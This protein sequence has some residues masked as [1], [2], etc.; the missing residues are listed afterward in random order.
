[1][2]KILYFLFFTLHTAFY[3]QAPGIQWQKCF[4]GSLAEL[5]YSI[6]QTTDGG[7]IAAG[8][9]SSSNGQV[10]ENH[11]VA[12]YW[13]VK[14]TSTG[15]LQWQKSLGGSGAESAS[16]VFQTTDGGYI[17]TGTSNSVDGDVTGNHGDLD[18][19]VVKMDPGGNLQWQ[20]SFGGSNIERAESI[21]QTTD[22]GYILAGTT[23]STDGDVTAN[24]GGQDYWV[25]KLSPDGNIQ[26][27]KSLGGSGWENAVSIQ[28]TTDGGYIV[29]GSTTDSLDGD[30]TENN[31]LY[32][33]WVVKLD[34]GGAIEW[35]KSYGGM[36]DDLA[37]SVQQTLDGGYIIAGTSSD[38]V[39]GEIPT[40]PGIPDYWIIKTDSLGNMEWNKLLGGSYHDNTQA[41]RPTQDGGYIIGGWSVSTD[42][43]VTGNHGNHD[44]WVTKLDN[45]GNLQWQKSLGGSNVDM[46]HSIEQT[47]DGGYIM[48]GYTFSTNG[49][50]SGNHGSVDFWVVKLFSDQLNTLETP[51]VNKTVLYP[52]PAKDIIFL[53]HL[54]SETMVQIT[55][56]AGRNLLNKKY[57]EEKININTSPFTNGMYMIQVQHK[58][59]ILLSEKLKIAK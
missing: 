26:W 48:L 56:M 58:G 23:S 50:V 28:Q 32:D 39:T 19:W 15:T 42:G 2:N 47:A 22:G 18:Y 51:S 12:D 11:G 21:Q 57:T 10:T 25:L 45:L 4:G 9:S 38:S 41:V 16:S 36:G 31:G 43:Q 53:D 46:L 17:A 13:I 34:T 1:M 7:Y 5:G 40:Y 6:R 37:Y 54:P 20:K 33:Y 55:D 52:N 30:I 35:E 29:A 59:K 24:H 49:D 3:S 27:E 44:Y 8:S 14:M